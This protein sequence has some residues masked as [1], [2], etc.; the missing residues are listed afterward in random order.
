M[1]RSRRLLLWGVRL[2]LW[3]VLLAFLW[4]CWIFAE[5]LWWRNHNPEWT[6]FM[7][8]R[9]ESR[10]DA[11]RSGI[12]PHP[13]VPYDRIPDSLKRAVV[14]AEDSG[15]VMHHGF[16]W[17]GMRIALEKDIHRGK[18][19]A[20]GSTI[21]QQLAKNLFLSGKRSLWRK[22]EEAVITVML[23]A[24]WS[25]RRILEVYLNVI[26]WGDGLFGCALATQHYYQEPVTALTPAQSARLASMIPSPRYFDRHGE[27]ER[28]LEKSDTIEQRMMLVPIP[29]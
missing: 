15:F 24:T 23:E 10:R 27:T 22:A 9:D 29:R 18:P 1:S 14:A 17:E 13:W 11:G 4:E 21:T 26:E 19:V 7:K 16:D 20:G 5:V 8:A 6:A 2:L 3:G 28:L 25:K 12:M